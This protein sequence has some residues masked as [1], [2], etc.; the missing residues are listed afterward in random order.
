MKGMDGGGRREVIGGNC[1]MRQDRK[2][3]FPV[4]TSFRESESLVCAQGDSN[5]AVIRAD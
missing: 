5:T 1:I 2:P 3:S 4:W